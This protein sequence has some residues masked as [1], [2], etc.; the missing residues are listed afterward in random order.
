[1]SLLT[2]QP[3][4]LMTKQSTPLALTLAQEEAWSITALPTTGLLHTL[5]Q[6]VEVAEQRQ[7]AF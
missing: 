4:R 1:M 6:E 7:L 2:L 5:A 3:R